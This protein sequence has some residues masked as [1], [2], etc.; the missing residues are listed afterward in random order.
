MPPSREALA[1]ELAEKNG[2]CG[3]IASGFICTRPKRECDGQHRGQ[4]IVRVIPFIKP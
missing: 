2:E 4:P 1:R 3:F